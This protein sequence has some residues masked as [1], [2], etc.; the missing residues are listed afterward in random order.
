[1]T[2]SVPPFF[3]RLLPE[4]ADENRVRLVERVENRVIIIAVCLIL[5]TVLVADIL[6]F[7]LPNWLKFIVLTALMYVFARGIWLIIHPRYKFVHPKSPEAVAL[8]QRDIEMRFYSDGIFQYHHNGFSVHANDRD[9]GIRWDEIDAILAYKTHIY[10]NNIWLS[11]IC[12]DTTKNFHLHEEISGWF[13]FVKEL[14]EKVPAFGEA[15]EAQRE[16]VQVQPTILYLKNHLIRE[17][18]LD[19]FAAQM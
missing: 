13:S 7:Y 9:I 2:I 16:R 11:V 12:N 4:V 18:I 3:S 1:V 17:H 6:P 15:W 14:K 8:M 5:W 10:S 19:V